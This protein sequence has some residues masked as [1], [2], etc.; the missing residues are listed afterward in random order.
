[1]DT[2]LFFFTVIASTEGYIVG[3]ALLTL[4]LLYR[5]EFRHARA[6]VL[7]AAGLAISTVLLKGFIAA[8][9]PATALIEVS[10]YG[11]PS[12]HAAGALFLALTFSIISLRHASFLVGGALSLL[13]VV[14][15]LL[16]GASRVYYHVHT[17]LQVIAGF[18]L[19]IAWVLLFLYLY[20]KK[21]AWQ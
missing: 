3:C 21:R 2:S 9:R 7:T 20:R 4:F 1:M 11:F 14:C 5:K 19:A 17:P 6:F 15:A 13:S 8:E 16:I 18:V 10:G 12:G